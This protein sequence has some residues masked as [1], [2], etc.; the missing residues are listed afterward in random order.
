MLYWNYFTD[1]GYGVV[2]FFLQCITVNIR[3]LMHRLSLLAQVAWWV[4][5]CMIG[6]STRIGQVSRFP[7]TTAMIKLPAA[8]WPNSY[9]AIELNRKIAWIWFW[10]WFC[11]TRTDIELSTSGAVQ[12]RILKPTFPYTGCQT[13][14]QTVRNLCVLATHSLHN[15]YILFSSISEL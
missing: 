2:L 4:K 13:V 12:N 7:L 10:Q 1:D 3:V 11:C 9:I 8:Y 15:F 14:N 6:D 5:N